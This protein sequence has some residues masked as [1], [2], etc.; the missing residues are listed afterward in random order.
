MTT[1]T[2]LLCTSMPKCMRMHTHTHAHK[3]DDS[4]CKV[5]HQ[6]NSRMITLTCL[7]CYSMRALKH[8]YLHARSHTHTH[9]YEHTRALVAFAKCQL[10]KPNK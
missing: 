10:P 7:L 8:T 2:L 6:S 5:T 1:L 3:N 9:I 4:I